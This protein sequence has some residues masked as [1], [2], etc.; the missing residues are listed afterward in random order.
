MSA[1]R[2]IR[3]ICLLLLICIFSQAI[4]F[5]MMHGDVT[6]RL[7]NRLRTYSELALQK[8]EV[9]ELRFWTLEELEAEGVFA[10]K[11]LMLVS[12]DHPLPKGYEPIL[13]EY[14]GARMHPEMVAPYIALRDTVEAKTG[15]RIYVSS[16]YRSAEEQDAI[17][18]ESLTG[19]A[20]PVGSSEH[21]AGLALDVYAPFFAGE[22][23]IKSAAGRAVGELCADYGFIIRYPPG[24]EDVTG[25]VYEPWHLRY[26][27]APHAEL[28]SES[29]M[30]LEEYV[31][32]LEIGQWYS[33]GE[34]LISRQS[35]DDLRLPSTW[36][37]LDLSL[38]NT[39]YCILTLKR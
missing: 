25:I 20:A 33:H 28:I 22:A 39:G 23:F 12:A 10:S 18:S 5:F 9:E 15:I 2:R 17:L 7:W 29:G 4:D 36:S 3:W 31:S 30:T 19:V 13:A 8:T 37:D 6:Y 38:D 14:N 1:A 21:E 27:G 16:D 11:L 26:V 24:K 32:A 34:Y 35:L